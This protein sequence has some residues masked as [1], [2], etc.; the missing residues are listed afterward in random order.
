MY[1]QN[2]SDSN[3]ILSP[4]RFRFA[5]DGNHAGLFWRLMAFIGCQ[6][7]WRRV[8]FQRPG[9]LKIVHLVSSG[10]CTFL[11]NT[12]FGIPK[13]FTLG[14]MGAPPP[15]YV[16]PWWV[17]LSLLHYNLKIGVY[18]QKNNISL[19]VILFCVYF[20]PKLF[21]CVLVTFGQYFS[22][23]NF[24]KICRKPRIDCSDHQKSASM[25]AH[26]WKPIRTLPLLRCVLQIR[27]VQLWK[28]MW[29]RTL[30]GS[31]PRC[32]SVESFECLFCHKFVVHTSS[33]NAIVDAT[34][35]SVL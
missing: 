5:L 33:L 35:G 6:F 9:T 17:L 3:V 31:C 29:M 18:K 12:I 21:I 34:I 1:V 32:M 2:T 13:K 4:P 19:F 24:V 11:C 20:F 23:F 22:K 28:M 27:H 8:G 26:G 25:L 10:Y 16:T 15:S 14:A 30:I 7:Q